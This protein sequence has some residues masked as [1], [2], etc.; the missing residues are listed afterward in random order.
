MSKESNYK[1]NLLNREPFSN[2]ERYT[3][4][5]THSAVA[6]NSNFHT[7][8][9]YE[10][11]FLIEGNIHY[12]VDQSC[13]HMKSGDLL[14]VKNNEI[15]KAL[16]LTSDPFTRLVIHIHPDIIRNYSTLNTNLYQCFQLALEGQESIRLDEIEAKELSDLGNRLHELLL[17]QIDRAYGD[18]LKEELLLI[19]LLLL[20]NQWYMKKNGN[21]KPISTGRI[22]NVMNYIDEHLTEDLTLDSIA[23]ALSMDKYHLSHIFKAE[24]QSSIFQ[25]ILVKRV[26]LAKDMLQKG[27]TVTESCQLSGFNDYTNFIRTFKKISGYTPGKY[28]KMYY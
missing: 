15:H 2:N 14:V 11:F 26:S 16:N 23:Y 6:G 17:K 13:Y 21:S 28:R 24:T 5:I 25:Y 8:N 20:V 18:D 1:E 3:C 22:I 19:E 10:I 4:N 7:H 12:Y 9:Y 27:Y